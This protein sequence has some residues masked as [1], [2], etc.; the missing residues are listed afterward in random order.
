MEQVVRLM[1]WVDTNRKHRAVSSQIRKQL[2]E[3]MHVLLKTIAGGLAPSTYFK[4]IFQ[5]LRDT[6][7]SVRK[8]VP[9]FCSTV[10]LDKHLL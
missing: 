3:K 7:I 2:K 4:V 1:Q 9:K 6:D 8:K 10:I 5:L